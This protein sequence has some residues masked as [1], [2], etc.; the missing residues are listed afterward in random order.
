MSQPLGRTQTA[1]RVVL[2]QSYGEDGVFIP[3][4][5]QYHELLPRKRII[6]L[7]VPR[8]TTSPP[9]GHHPVDG[10]DQTIGQCR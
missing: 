7:L 2:V 6:S 1:A 3:T 10:A 5:S 8:P 4:H 9:F